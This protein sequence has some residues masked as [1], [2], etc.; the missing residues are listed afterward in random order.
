MTQKTCPVAQ[1]IQDLEQVL[2]SGRLHDAKNHRRGEEIL[3][4]L[5]DVAWG[6]AGREHLPA[7]RQLSEEMRREGA[8]DAGAESGGRILTA[9]EDAA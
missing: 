1:L 4:L 2:A 7:I 8:A 6:R 9:L 5:N 3:A